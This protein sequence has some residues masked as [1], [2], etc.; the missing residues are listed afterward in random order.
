MASFTP[1][2]VAAASKSPSRRVQTVTISWIGERGVSES[3]IAIK[4][5]RV[6]LA[7]LLYDQVGVQKVIDRLM[8]VRRLLPEKPATEPPESR[9]HVIE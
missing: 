2:T 1:S 5:D 6:E 9:P 4:D 3:S 7:A 8:A